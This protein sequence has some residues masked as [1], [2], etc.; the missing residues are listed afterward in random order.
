MRLTDDSQDTVLVDKIHYGSKDYPC[1]WFDYEEDDRKHSFLLSTSEL[2]D[3][4]FSV[5]G[6]YVSKSAQSLDEKIF[7]FAPRDIVLNATDKE[8]SDYIK[9]NIL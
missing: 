2:N 1:R 3:V 4:L 8:L 9:E 7:C 6:G 5:S